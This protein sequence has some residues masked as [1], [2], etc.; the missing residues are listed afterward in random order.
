MIAHIN[1]HKNHITALA[2]ILI[3]SGF[4]FGFV[5]NGELKDIALISA[6]ILASIP[7]FIKAIQALRM[8]A[9]ALIC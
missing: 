7:I 4:I 2:S 8:K 6:T 5:G 1:H 9:S 3:I